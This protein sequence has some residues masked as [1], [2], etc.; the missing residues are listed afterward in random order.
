MRTEQVRVRVSKDNADHLRDLAQESG[1]QQI[2]IATMLLHAS[3]L[4][5]R[6]AGH[7]SFPI[8]FAVQKPPR[9]VGGL[10]LNDKGKK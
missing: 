8:R 9:V 2:E 3:L 7:A 4:A 6:E 1:L 10:E 5:I